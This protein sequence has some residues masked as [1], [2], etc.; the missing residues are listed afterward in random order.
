MKLKL[1][2]IEFD[3]LYQLLAAIINLKVNNNSYA[4]KLTIALLAKTY[5]RFYKKAMVKKPKYTVSL[6]A[7]EALNWY[8]FFMSPNVKLPLQDLHTINLIRTINHSIHHQYQ[9]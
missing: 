9:N 8:L 3:A 5:F 7:E 4:D 6:P 1:T 2:Y